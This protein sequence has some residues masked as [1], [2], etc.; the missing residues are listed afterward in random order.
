MNIFEE[1]AS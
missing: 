1:E